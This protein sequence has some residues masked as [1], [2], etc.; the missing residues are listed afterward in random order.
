[1]T[2]WNTSNEKRPSSNT[3]CVHTQNIKIKF[4]T[5]REKKKRKTG[6]RETQKSRLVSTSKA[7]KDCS[8]TSYQHRTTDSNSESAGGIH[9]LNNFTSR[10][11]STL[12]NQSKKS[13]V[14]KNQIKKKSK[15]IKASIYN[16]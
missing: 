5:K 1:M 15:K 16:R 7:S 4:K 14:K 10:T 13:E 12:E 9:T 11:A 6:G 2:P 8:V 3:F